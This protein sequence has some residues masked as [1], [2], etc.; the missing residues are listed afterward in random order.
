[1]LRLTKQKARHALNQLKE[2]LLA[3]FAGK[4]QLYVYGSVARGDFGPE[5]DIDVLVLLEQKMDYAL[6]DEIYD[7]AFDIE[8]Q[9]N[10]VFGL[11]IESQVDWESPLLQAMPI[12]K[13]IDREGIPA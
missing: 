10:V 11:L 9:E 6:K 3:R 7:L 2:K 5:S 8:L 1:M 12:H 4:V 13:E